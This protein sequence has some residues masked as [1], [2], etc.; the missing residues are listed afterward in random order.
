MKKSFE[1]KDKDEELTNKLVGE[2]EDKNNVAKVILN[3]KRKNGAT[4]KS[5]KNGKSLIFINRDTGNT[6]VLSHEV[7]HSYYISGE[8]EKKLGGKIHKLDRKI[9]N[10]YQGIAKKKVGKEDNFENLSKEERKDKLSSTRK[11]IKGG[12][13]SVVSGLTGL[14]A[15]YESAKEKEKENKN[16]ARLITAGS[17]A[18]PVLGHAPELGREIAASSKGMKYLKK[19]G[20]SKEQLKRS[21]KSMAYALGTYGVGLGK[22]LII[23]GGGQLVGRGVYKLSHKK[24]ND[25]SNKSEEKTDKDINDNKL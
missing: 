14:A 18:V 7:G 9:N 13:G 10:V 8:G 19:A 3:S 12:V 16:M 24:K 25:K 6:A 4:D 11:N 15:G 23:N 1:Y 17:L 5:D 2:A 21:R 22:N 20:A